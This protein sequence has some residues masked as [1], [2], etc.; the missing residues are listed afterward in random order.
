MATAADKATE[1]KK[2]DS[3]FGKFVKSR[4]D[5]LE[6]ISNSGSPSTRE[7]QLSHRSAAA[8]SSMAMQLRNI[9]NLDHEYV[10]GL[11]EAVLA[12]HMLPGHKEEITQ[13]LHTKVCCAVH[14]DC[15]FSDNVCGMCFCV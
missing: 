1:Q 15:S 3:H 6:C 7:A 14:M 2:L 8:F 12:S 5:L 4:L 10:C 11:V 13:L 9:D